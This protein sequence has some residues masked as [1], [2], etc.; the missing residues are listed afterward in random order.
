MSSTH[1]SRVLRLIPDTIHHGSGRFAPVPHLTGEYEPSTSAWVREQVETYERTGGRE[2]GTLLQTGIPVVIVSMRGRASGKVRK[3][4]LMRVEHGGEYLL[5]ASKGGADTHPD[6]YYN[7]VANP[8][9]VTVQDGPEPFFATVREID[10]DEY[11]T[12]WERAVAVFAPYANYR[13]KTPRRIPLFLAS[14]AV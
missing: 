12:W 6:W 11:D 3:I 5:V 1:A 2:A 10:G 4:A 7:L 9:E 14:P 8:T 13:E